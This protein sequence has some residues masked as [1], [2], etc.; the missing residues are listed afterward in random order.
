MTLKNEQPILPIIIQS[1]QHAYGVARSFYEAYRIKSLVIEPAIKVRTIRSLFLSGTQGI[2]TQNSGILDFQYVE[3]LN[4]PAYFVQALIGVAMQFQHQ[5]LILLVCDCYYAEL[6]IENKEVLEKYFIL[7]YIDQVL[8]KKVQTKEKFYQLCD[9]YQLKYPKT[10]ILTKE[11]QATSELPFQFPIIIK[12][13]NAVTYTSCSFPEK[14]K[15]FLVNDANEMQHIVRCIYRS[16]YQDA[17]ILQEFIPGDDSYIR[18]LDVYVGRDNKVKLMCVSN[19]LLEDPSPQ[20]KGISLAVM[21]DYDEQLM[22]SIRYL[23]EDIG[24]TGFANFDMKYDVRDGEYKLFE[25]NLRSGASSYY[26]T[27]SGHNLM[28]YMVDDYLFHVNHE[29]TY[30]QTK[31][32]WTLL[33]SKTLYKYMQNEKLK[34]EA[35]RLI[36]EGRYTNALFY[37]EDMNIKRWMKLKLYNWYLHVKYRKYFN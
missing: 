6:I 26:V 24:Y 15:I 7:P 19:K 22:D 1:G 28:Q 4:E 3:H 35:K 33:P 2:A 32:L 27:A 9:M 16:S 31:H 34:I 5:K 29:R 10:M 14:K 11:H 30:V 20:N 36:R 18:V 25:M 37:K 12:P 13:S 17:L 23:L 8:L 21:T